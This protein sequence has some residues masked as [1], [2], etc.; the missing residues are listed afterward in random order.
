MKENVQFPDYGSYLDTYSQTPGPTSKW[1]SDPWILKL[2]SSVCSFLASSNTAS[3]DTWPPLF[4]HSN[5][6]PNSFVTPTE[7]I[8]LLSYLRT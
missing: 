1:P 3:P 7:S 8:H 4:A 2:H 6:M 5:T